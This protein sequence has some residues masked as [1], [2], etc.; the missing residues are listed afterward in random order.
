M[1]PITIMGLL[2]IVIMLFPHF[3]IADYQPPKS[4]SQ[5]SEIY[6]ND[7]ELGHLKVG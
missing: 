5:V 3:G 4:V 6:R 7:I 1:R 2:V